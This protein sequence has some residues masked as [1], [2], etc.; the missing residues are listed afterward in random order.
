M[1]SILKII[2]FMSCTLVLN[3]NLADVTQAR[4][5]LGGDPCA[6]RKGGQPNLLKCDLEIRQGIH[7]I[8]G[9]V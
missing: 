8:T 3:L 6:D 7:T 5:R 2:V 1:V 9:E 4:H